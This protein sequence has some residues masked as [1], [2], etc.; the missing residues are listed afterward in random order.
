MAPGERAPADFVRGVLRVRSRPRE[1]RRSTH[2][3][4]RNDANVHG[5]I[6]VF[7]SGLVI[8]GHRSDPGSTPGS[9]AAAGLKVGVVSFGVPGTFG[10]VSAADPGLRP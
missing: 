4:L 6:K 9:M 1:G 2:V 10:G 5:T 3:G 7:I 8:V